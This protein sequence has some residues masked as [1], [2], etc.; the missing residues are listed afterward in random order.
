VPAVDHPELYVRLVI[1]SRTAEAKGT[2]RKL[3]EFADAEA[4]RQGIPNLR[5]DC[6][7]GGSG[8]LVEFYESCGYVRSSTFTVG[9]WPGQLLEKRL[10]LSLVE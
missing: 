3:M 2:G 10:D 5:V 1:A 9:E 4:R 6:F 7:A 8:R